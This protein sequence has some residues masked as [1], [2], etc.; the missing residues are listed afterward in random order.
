MSGGGGGEFLQA[1]GQWQIPQAIRGLSP[2][3]TSAS[4]LFLYL[5]KEARDLFPTQLSKELWG[6]FT[7]IIG[8]EELC[9]QV[10]P[11]LALLGM[12]LGLPFQSYC[13][14]A[15][16]RQAIFLCFAGFLD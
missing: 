9:Q 14:L 1:G 4:N 3:P 8:V 7:K 15:S 16:G 12:F 5:Q 11:N 13:F 10:P 2:S 6:G